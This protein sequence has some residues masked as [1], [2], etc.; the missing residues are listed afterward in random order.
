MVLDTFIV[1]CSKAG[2]ANADKAIT[3][4]A[5][6]DDVVLVFDQALFSIVWPT[7]VSTLQ[8]FNL[9]VEKSKC[10][11]WIPDDSAPAAAVQEAVSSDGITIVT[12]G[13]T[14]L[15]TAA[16]GEH[17][18]LITL[19]HDSTDIVVADVRARLQHA[20]SDAKLLVEMAH[21]SDAKL[22]VEMA[23][24]P[25]KQHIKYAAWLMLCRSLA[26]RLDF[27][28]R[29]LP[30]G[31]LLSTLS[32]FNTSILETARSIAELPH[33]TSGQM[34]QLQLP[35]HLGGLFFTNPLIKLEVAHLSSVAASWHPTY[36][37]QLE[38]WI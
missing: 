35:G 37:W 15:G 10:N 1:N 25:T 4:M 21:Q 13:L 28:M 32:E 33:L 36:L 23:Q 7:Y 29:I 2:I 3:I 20:Q 9:L 11:A 16:A 34:S 27:D 12:G 31:V 5:Y 38:K 8:Q 18:T 19:N 14:V 6:V 24:T 22:L 17:A 30:K 26:V